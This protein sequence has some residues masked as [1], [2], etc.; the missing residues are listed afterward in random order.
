MYKHHR[1]PH[2]GKYYRVNTESIKHFNEYTFNKTVH[3]NDSYPMIVDP[4]VCGYCDTCFQSRNKLFYH[5]GFMG[6]NIETDTKYQGESRVK[7]K[8][9]LKYK[10]TSKRDRFENDLCNLFSKVL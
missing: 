6:I 8:I 5:L 2:N 1:N 9:I 4:Y 7:R 10:K 3:N